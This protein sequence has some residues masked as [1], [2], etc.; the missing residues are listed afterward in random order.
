[1]EKTGRIISS[2]FPPLGALTKYWLSIHF[3]G[4]PYG[5]TDLLW[6]VLITVILIGTWYVFFPFRSKVERLSVVWVIGVN[7]GIG[8][9]IIGWI[10][11]VELGHHWGEY[12]WFYGLWSAC[13]SFIFGK[14]FKRHK[15]SFLK[16]PEP[17]ED[18]QG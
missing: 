17:I 4:D 10:F 16:S 2:V 13:Y 6:A 9:M 12:M 15:M 7:F 8:L 14:D 5:G 1:M 3:G 11:G 18:A